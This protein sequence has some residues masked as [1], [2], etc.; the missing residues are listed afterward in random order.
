MI[1]R[2]HFVLAALAA[3]ALPARAHHG[4]SSFD[5]DKPVYLAGTVKS[6]RWQN[7]HAE[8]M[9]TVAPGLA[10]PADLA[11]RSAPPQSQAVDGAAI[12]KKAALPPQAAGE[13]VVELAPLS[14]MNAW[15]APELKAGEKIE[16]VGYI[17]ASGKERVLRVE[18]LMAGGRTYGL[19]SSPQ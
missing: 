7:P 9:L 12:F 6:V 4:W 18:Y 19:R 14:R 15:S 2:R 13:W 16:V 11:A 8:V 10:L 1:T 17:L 3:G 5:Q